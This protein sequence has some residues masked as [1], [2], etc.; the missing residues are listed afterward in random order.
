M[1]P[2]TILATIIFALISIGH[3]LRLIFQVQVVAAGLV[4]PMWLSIFGCL[5]AAMIAIL[6]WRENRRPS[7][8]RE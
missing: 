3:L 7:M 6:M 2:I 5:F 4:I 1:K 8:P